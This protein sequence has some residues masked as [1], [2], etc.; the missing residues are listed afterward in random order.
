MIERMPFVFCLIIVVAALVLAFLSWKTVS[1]SNRA[2]GTVI[3][4]R[5]ATDCCGDAPVVKYQVE[6]GTYS[7]SGTAFT[8]YSAYSVGEKVTVLYKPEQPGEGTINSFTELWFLPTGLGGMGLIGSLMSWFVL[9]KESP[10][11]R[12]LKEILADPGLTPRQRLL[13]EKLYGISKRSN[14]YLDLSS[15]SRTLRPSPSTLYGF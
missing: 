15:T 13:I 10:P 7:A 9:F 3:S 11:T 8:T 6:G 2:E 5:S 14:Y 1:R 12:P 4:M